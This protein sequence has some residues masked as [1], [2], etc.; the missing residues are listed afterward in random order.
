MRFKVLHF[1]LC[2][3]F[4]T[5]VYSQST[6]TN[7]LPCDAIDLGTISFGERLGDFTQGLYNNLCAD[8]LNE[9][10]PFDDGRRWNDAGVWFT[11]TT[12]ANPGFL[13]FEA[14][15]DPENTG[16]PIGLELAI[17]EFDGSCSGSTKLLKS[18]FTPDSNDE[19]WTFQCPRPNTTYYIMV[20]GL[21]I[22]DEMRKGVFGLQVSSPLVNKGV[23]QIC[24]AVSLGQLSEGGSLS[25]DGLWSN[26][27]ANAYRD[28]K[29]SAFNGEAG[30]WFEFFA[31]ASGH[32]NINVIPDSTILPINPMIAVFG[33]NR[34]SCTG[35]FNRIW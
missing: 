20:D 14:K 26:F 19:S 13:L 3:L 8:N 9:P 35:N 18:A 33:N 2:I 10:N 34:E 4:T 32:I 1:L 21:S 22:N 6:C 11:V 25:P 17:Y 12:D 24:D 30:I 23:D 7:D 16:D 27:C 28:P 31:P 5:K 15:N 29:A